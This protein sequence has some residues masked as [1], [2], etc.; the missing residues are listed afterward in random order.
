M[1]RNW[2][3]RNKIRALFKRMERMVEKKTKRENN[4][5]KLRKDEK[6]EMMS[7]KTDKKSKR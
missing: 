1:V 6:I 4:D 5:W 2:K 7:K 3:D